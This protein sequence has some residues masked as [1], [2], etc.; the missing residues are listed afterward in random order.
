MSQ[1][2]QILPKSIF[3]KIFGLA[4]MY[5]T[6]TPY[7]QNKLINFPSQSNEVHIPI[8]YSAFLSIF[9]IFFLIFLYLNNEFSA[10]I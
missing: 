5:Q 8:D 3:K 7:M 1:G 9:L 4:T 10:K 2:K 6:L